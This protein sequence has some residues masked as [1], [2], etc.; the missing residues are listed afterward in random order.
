MDRSTALPARRRRLLRLAAL[1]LL[2]LAAACAGGY[3]RD[4]LRV[5]LVGLEPLPAEGMEWRMTAKLRVQNPNPESLTFEGVSL[6]LD[7]RGMSFASGVSPA[8]G[9]VPAFGET[10][11]ALPVTVSALA[12]ARQVIGMA[13]GGDAKFD[14]ALRGRFGGPMAGARFDETGSVDLSSLAAAR[15]RP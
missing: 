11:V 3:G 4:A 5:Q 1:A 2:P 13:T 7:L 15:P 8:S 6:T 14:Y 12:A 9:T 10:V